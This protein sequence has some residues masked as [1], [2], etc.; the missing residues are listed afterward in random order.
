[1]RDK[2]GEQV[3]EFES[4]LKPDKDSKIVF[5]GTPQCEDSLYNKLLERDYTSSIWT[6]KYITPEKNE[7][8]YFGRVSPLCVSKE[9][10]GKSTEPLRFSE[11]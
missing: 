5:L 8:T 10:E 1:M 9:K 11:L 4:I 7:K 6:C 3:K 2:L